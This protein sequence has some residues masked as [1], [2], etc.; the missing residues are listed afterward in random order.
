MI[1]LNE[2]TIIYAHPYEKSF[3]HEILVKVKENLTAQ[4]RPYTVL[5]LY[6]D[7]FNPVFSKE[8]LSYYSEGRALDPLVQ[9]YQ[10]KITEAQDLVFIFP[11]WW[12]DVPAIVKGF[13]D[14]V[15]LKN[16][17]FSDGGAH[18]EGMLTHIKT[19]K[20]ITT[21]EEKTAFIRESTGNAIEQVLINA[22]FAHIGIKNAEWINRDQISQ[23]SDEERQQFLATLSI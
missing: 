15:M 16:F 20:V 22:T 8:E 4:N 13:F 5:D 12:N 19:A 10:E 21:S 3:N 1:I 18:I 14:K 9:T 6:A 11:I 2:V 17:A 23:V 7:D